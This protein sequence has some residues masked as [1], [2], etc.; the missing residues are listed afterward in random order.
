MSRDAQRFI[1]QHIGAYQVTGVLGS[2]GMGVVLRALQP[3]LGREV[4]LKLMLDGLYADEVART[5]FLNEA[6]AMA[7]LQHSG[8]IG[9]HDVGVHGGFPYYAMDLVEGTELG[10]R[11]DHLAPRR[12]ATLLAQVAEA[13]EYVHQ[14]GLIHRDIK[15]ANILIDQ[16]QRALLMDFGLVKDTHSTGGLTSE[17]DLLG[18]PAY[19]APEQASGELSRVDHRADVYGLGA[20]L[21]RG[22]AGRP[23]YDG[24]S[25]VNIVTKLIQGPPPPPSQVNP[26]VSAELEAVCLKAMARDPGE[27]HASA[28]ELADDL[29]G[30]VEGRSQPARS[31]RGPLMLVGLGGGLGAVAVGAFL[32][33]G[34][35]GATA[36]D[37]AKTPP[38]GTV[39]AKTAASA[40]PQVD[41][42][43]VAEFDAFLEAVGARKLSDLKRIAETGGPALR[44]AASAVQDLLRAAREAPASASGPLRSHEIDGKL[45]RITPDGPVVEVGRRKAWRVLL[46]WAALSGKALRSLAAHTAKRDPRLDL[47]AA[48][49]ELVDGHTQGI[50]PLLKALVGDSPAAG[51]LR[52]A[53]ELGVRRRLRAPRTQAQLFL[54]GRLTRAEEQAKTLEEPASTYG[55]AI[56]AYLRGRDARG[57]RLLSSIA[58]QAQRFDPVAAGLLPKRGHAPLPL[59][60]HAILLPDGRTRIEYGFDHPDELKDW[61][62]LIPDWWTLEQGALMLNK[63]WRH[64]FSRIPFQ[65]VDRIQVEAL[66]RHKGFWPRFRVYPQSSASPTRGMVLAYLGRKNSLQLERRTQRAQDAIRGGSAHLTWEKNERFR[67]DIVR[68]ERTINA[69]AR[70]KRVT[71]ITHAGHLV[72]GAGPSWSP[73]AGTGLDR[74]VMF[75]V[76]RPHARHP[77]QWV[78][79]DSVRGMRAVALTSLAPTQRGKGTVRWSGRSVSLE[80]PGPSPWGWRKDHALFL[81]LRPLAVPFEVRAHVAR[82]RTGPRDEAGLALWIGNGKYVRWRGNCLQLDNAMDS[83]GSVFK[84]RGES[85]RPEQGPWTLR[86]RRAGRLLW[87]DRSS[88]GGRTWQ[89]ELAGPTVW[90]DGPVTI[91]FY[92]SS[93]AKGKLGARFTDVQVRV[94]KPKPN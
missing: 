46:P 90:E 2:G 60:G 65:R 6:R 12:L 3:A 56:A 35:L 4:A 24:V 50:A 44:P 89:D 67:V 14:S 75:G 39:D 45:H 93:Q 22:L 38:T 11:I 76:V 52:G 37:S 17:G 77:T 23:P 92:V 72:P 34:S 10:Q 54:S 27:R 61:T 79:E 33:A 53:A 25:Q 5:R 63:K 21:Y 81:K 84:G 26:D 40:S 43:S 64:A 31:S 68:G 85:A 87:V 9:I 94:G 20:V 58:K 41:A 1:G 57:A 19:M 70:G 66:Y 30:Y 55:R 86:L 28:A 73:V 80:V 51:A 18:T 69:E 49:I 48:W 7:R 47:G 36:T 8:L 13:L 88:D 83:W 82:S 59:Y 71:A 16:H 29:L 42:P 78:F 74:I 62:L 91:G 15:P 32:Y